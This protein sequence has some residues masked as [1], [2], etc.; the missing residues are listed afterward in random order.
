MNMEGGRREEK[1]TMTLG[2]FKPLVI[3]SRR[4][5]NRH[6]FY[7]IPTSKEDYFPKRK[8]IISKCKML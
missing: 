3:G 1:E 4:I 2:Y 5:K 8:K 6:V 7:I